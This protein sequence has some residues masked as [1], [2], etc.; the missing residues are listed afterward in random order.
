MVPYSDILRA[1]S[2]AGVQ[3]LVAGG[4]ALNLHQ[5]MR[6]TVDLD[7]IIHLE[8]SNVKKFVQVMQALGFRPKVPVDPLDFADEHK[9]KTWIV[10]KNMVVFSFINLN[11]PMEVVDIF[12]EEPRPFEEL[13]QRRHEVRLGDAVVAVLGAEDLIA[14]KE[15]A[16]RPKDLY[17]IKLLK[18]RRDDEPK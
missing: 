6:M 1:I 3:Y 8:S 14:L 7:L 15:A 11:N 10:E 16:G 2:Q 5:L 13:Y 9:R 18:D 17:D 12:V 4:V